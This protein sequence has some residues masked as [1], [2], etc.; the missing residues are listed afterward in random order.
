LISSAIT[1]LGTTNVVNSKIQNRN[2]ACFSGLFMAG[3]LK[4]EWIR[5]QWFE[6]QGS[7]FR[8]QGLN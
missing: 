1:A 6:I 5:V 4:G 3:L 2:R 8:V 7:G